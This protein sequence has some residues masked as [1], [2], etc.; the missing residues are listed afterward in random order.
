[1]YNFSVYA[2][3]NNK[4]VEGNNSPCQ[5]IYGEKHG[6]FKYQFDIK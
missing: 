4:N 3:D 6:W 2:S 5:Q 1:M